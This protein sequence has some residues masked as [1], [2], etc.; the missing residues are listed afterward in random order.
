[1]PN[2][3]GNRFLPQSVGA[4]ER[5]SRHSAALLP[6]ARIHLE[7]LIADEHD[8][9]CSES[10]RDLGAPSE[11][12]QQTNERDV[13]DTSEIPLKSCMD[14]ATNLVSNR[15]VIEGTILRVCA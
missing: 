8:L 11:Q 3:L 4:A 1:M 5:R 10:G 2:A 14:L 13:T 7:Y 6:T 9:D 15:D 12:V